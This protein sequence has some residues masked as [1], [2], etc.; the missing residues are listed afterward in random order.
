[1]LSYFGKAITLSNLLSLF[2][3]S[4]KHAFKLSCLY[5]LFGFVALFVEVPQVKWSRCRLRKRIK[6]GECSCH[7]DVKE[8]RYKQLL[9]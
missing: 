3:R 6:H 1:M 7:V 8:S 4:S 9:Q 2:V 5:S